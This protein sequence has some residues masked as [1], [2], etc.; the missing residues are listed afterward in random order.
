MSKCATKETVVFTWQFGLCTSIKEVFISFHQKFN[1][2]H[3]LYGLLCF[4]DF[5]GY[6]QSKFSSNYA[7][8]STAIHENW[9]RQ[10]NAN[11]NTFVHR[12]ETEIDSYGWASFA[13]LASLCTTLKSSH[14]AM[15]LFVHEYWLCKLMAAVQ[16]L[17]LNGSHVDLPLSEDH[18]SYLSPTQAKE[19]SVFKFITSSLLLS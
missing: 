15:T 18:L 3:Y 1:P 17:A 8:L 14:H 11:F 13:G 6:T 2:V 12:I 5:I 9:G 19:T 4:Q 16:V 7:R 10:R